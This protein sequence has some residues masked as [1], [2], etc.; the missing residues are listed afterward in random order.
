MPTPPE[1]CC[2]CLPAAGLAH[3][4]PL[5]ARA[6]L[7]VLLRDGRAW[8]FWPAGD[9][10]LA[11][12]VLAIA[13]AEL[14][15]RRDGAWYRLGRHLPAFDVPGEAG[16]RPLASALHPAPLRP[17]ASTTAA[18]RPLRARLVRDDRPRP[19]SAL[20]CTLAEL[21]RWAEGAT[22][23]QLAGLEA[24]T[25]A[26]WVLLRGARLPALAGAARFWGRAVLVP[27]GWRPEPALPEAALAAALGLAPDEL[28]VLGE[29]EAELVPGGAFGPVTRAG[30]RLALRE[31]TS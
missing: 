14:F 11:R 28:A 18:W 17:E 26:G 1:A 10:G 24:A 29:A 27:L 15:A 16:A 8:A 5:R 19:A 7:R 20:R 4:A 3:L 2:A 6:D 23:H 12:H 31:A 13:G 9:A 25:C 22:S 30:V 21:G